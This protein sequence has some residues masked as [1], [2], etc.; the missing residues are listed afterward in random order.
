[1]VGELDVLRQEGEEYADK[2]C[3]ASVKYELIVME[4]M[5]HAFLAMD[6][7]LAAGRQAIT[8]M[9]EAFME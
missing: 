8:K 2:L 1:M 7:V 3:K 6:G 9:V 5:P 4:K